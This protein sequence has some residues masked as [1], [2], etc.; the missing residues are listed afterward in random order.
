MISTQLLLPQ[1]SINGLLDQS[2]WFDNRRH[3]GYIFHSGKTLAVVRRRTCNEIQITHKINSSQFKILAN[4]QAVPWLSGDA[5]PL[6]VSTHHGA[7]LTKTV[8]E[9]TMHGL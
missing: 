2:P 1:E 9:C 7:A 8:N 3:Y 4:S 6:N 5:T